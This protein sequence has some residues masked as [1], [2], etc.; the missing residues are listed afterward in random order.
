MLQLKSIFTPWRTA[1]LFFGV[2]LA[3]GFNIFQDYGVAWDE[4]AQRSYGLM[5]WNYVFHGDR[6]LLTHRD[7]YHGPVYELLLIGV[8]KIL[9]AA[10]T[11][12][13]IFQRHLANYL[14]FM[15]G[16]FFFFLLGWKFYHDWK[17]G[18]LGAVLLVL[19]PRIFAHAF[20]NSK[21]L[22]FMTMGIICTYTLCIFL[23][24]KTLL[25]AIVH[26]ATCAFCL[27]IRIVGI[28]WPLMTLFFWL[29]DFA[30][31]RRHGIPKKDNPDQGAAAGF[32]SGGL[33]YAGTLCAFT[34]LFWP[35]LWDGPVRHLTAA[36]TQ[37]SRYPYV[38][39]YQVYLGEMID[40]QHLPW[41]YVPVWMTVSIPAL[42]TMLAAAGLAG[43]A[44]KM[45]FRRPPMACRREEAVMMAWLGAPL[46]YVMVFRPVLYDSWRHLFLIYP[47]LLL[48]ALAGLRQTMQ[49]VQNRWPAVGPSRTR[50]LA[51][52]AVAAWLFTIAAF[53]IRN[54]PYQNMFF[55]VFTAGIQ[56]AQ[57]RFELDYWGLS[58]RQG[59]E[60][61]LANDKNPEIDIWVQNKPGRENAYILRPEQMKR[62]VYLQ[63]A[64]KTDYGIMNYRGR[65][66][67]AGKYH[68]KVHAVTVD[69]VEILGVYQNTKNT[70]GR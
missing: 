57:H 64:D 12:E 70:N 9:G 58:Y 11:R 4:R 68:Q 40:N 38:V 65:Q 67:S 7:R 2:L 15:L 59:L 6:T 53:M 55:S 30:R 16:V 50:I 49:L 44:H 34:L 18:L 20:Y 66:R 24:R 29:R 39:G 36:F 69:G 1:A 27:S 31:L 63:T 37:M 45:I 62:L 8:E 56:G 35:I 61:I 10:T 23:E 14:F 51:G 46:L 3:L 19:S 32:L 28:M 25:A 47:A 60:Y 26:G 42:Y 13:L 22:P 33:V 52:G 17:W 21:D 54:H 5:T 41:H 48:L 43:F